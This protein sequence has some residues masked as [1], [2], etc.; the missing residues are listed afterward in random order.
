MVLLSAAGL[1][2]L[3]IE[4]SNANSERSHQTYFDSRMVITTFDIFLW[5]MLA[6][7]RRLY[8]TKVLVFGVLDEVVD[9]RQT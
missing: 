5:P 7:I 6:A 9:T 4:R 2:T 1:R 3:S 8:A